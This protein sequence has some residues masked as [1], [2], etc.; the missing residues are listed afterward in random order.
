MHKNCVSN[1]QRKL[2]NNRTSEII[3]LDATNYITN[4]LHIIFFLKKLR[5]QFCLNW[6]G[7]LFEKVSKYIVLIR[8]LGFLNNFAG[9]IL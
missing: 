7:T 8:R 6:R 2:L 4:I 5:N 1:I 9:N 3:N